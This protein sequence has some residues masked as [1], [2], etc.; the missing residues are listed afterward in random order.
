MTEGLKRA[1]QEQKGLTQLP[2][3]PILGLLCDFGGVLMR[4]VNPA[5]RS[6]LGRRF[7]LSREGLEELVFGD[8]AWDQAQLGYITS[9]EFW[10]GIGRRLGLQQPA[11]IAELRRA[12]WSGDRLDE[13]LVTIL[14]HLHRL[15]YR[16]GLLSNGPTDLAAYIGQL[17]GEAFDALVVSGRIGVMKPAPLAYQLALQQLGTRAEETVFVD[18]MPSNIAAASRLGLHAIHFR[19]TAVLRYQLR[20]LGL[21]IPA[22]PLSPVPN[23]RAVVFDWGGVVDRAPDEAHLAHWASLLGVETDQLMDALW[24]K[25]CQL[26]EIGAIS[27]EEF[28][29]RT[30][31]RLRLPDASAAQRFLE[32]FYRYDSLNH[33]VLET[34][35]LLRGRYTI[36]LLTNAGPNLDEWVR[37][38]HGLELQ[39]EFDLVINSSQVGARKPDPT[40]YH[41]LLD[42]LGVRPEQVIYLDDLQ[43]NVDVARHLRIHALQFVNPTFSLPEL[44]M[45]LG[46]P[47]RRG[48]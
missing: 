11:E 27:A 14:R 22:P 5:A 44:E 26:L 25:E 1:E 43:R 29:Q 24:G 9:E 30:A 19:G 38:T 28:A 23:V 18:D 34:I 36:A 48:T 42:R 39:R 17:T 2:T 31:Q 21:P 8:P 35:R 10:T 47:I 45:L 37:R 3:K 40:I 15:G 12:F 13:E 6:D 46:H 41:L 33:E 16:V 32:E 20:A 7:N 4:T